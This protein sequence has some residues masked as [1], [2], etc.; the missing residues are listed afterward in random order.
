M[1]IMT[2]WRQERSWNYNQETNQTANFEIHY[3]LCTWRSYFMTFDASNSKYSVIQNN[4]QSTQYGK[5][6][7]RTQVNLAQKHTIDTPYLAFEGESWVINCEYFWVKE[8]D[9]GISRVHCTGFKE[10]TCKLVLYHQYRLTFIQPWIRDS[11]NY[12]VWDET[13]YPV[14]IVNS[15]TVDVWEWISNI[16]S[17]F[18]GHV[19]TYPY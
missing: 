12:K 19:I 8:N 4:T 7:I 13:T 16:I 6:R 17:H 3:S 10:Q 15:A 5:Y 2:T 11:I 14:S 1:L 9:G 18:N